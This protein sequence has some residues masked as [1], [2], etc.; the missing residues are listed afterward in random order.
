MGFFNTETLLSFFGPAHWNSNI[1]KKHS[2][3][4]AEKKKKNIWIF[5]DQYMFITER[6]KRM[7]HSIIIFSFVSLVVTIPLEIHSVQHYIH[8]KKYTFLKNA[9]AYTYMLLEYTLYIV[10]FFKVLK[11]ELFK[12]PE[13]SGVKNFS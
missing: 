10:L 8:I 5:L 2:R 1:K 6:H 12:K 7:K 3:Y 11:K 9:N 13:Y 4:E